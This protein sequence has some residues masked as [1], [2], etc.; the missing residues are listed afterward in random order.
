[1]Q[2][3]VPSVTS[4]VCCTLDRPVLRWFTIHHGCVTDNQKVTNVVLPVKELQMRIIKVRLKGISRILYL[5][6]FYGLQLSMLSVKLF[7]K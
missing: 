4:R 2:T 6:Q 1:M 5:F 3:L 7:L